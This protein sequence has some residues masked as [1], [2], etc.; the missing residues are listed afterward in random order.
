MRRDR[1]AFAADRPIARFQENPPKLMSVFR[2]YAI[3]ALA[4][5]V[6]LRR[7]PPWRAGAPCRIRVEESR[8]SARLDQ[9]T[10]DTEVRTAAARRVM[11][12]LAEL[13]RDSQG[14]RFGELDLIPAEPLATTLA[15]LKSQQLVE[16][17]VQNSPQPWRLTL[18]GWLCAQRVAGYFDSDAFNERR[19]R[20]CAA[21][22]KMVKGRQ[23]DV[24]ASEQQ[25]ADRG[26]SRIAP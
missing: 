1:R 3:R 22:K 18:N 14:F 9:I 5:D 16:L 15:E 20:L 19:G 12:L 4:R 17:A 26:R 24:F 21:M 13:S 8:M 23:G 25:A 2:W 6:D 7:R 11:I 10:A